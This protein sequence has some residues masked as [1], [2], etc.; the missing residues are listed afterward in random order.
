MKLIRKPIKPAW[1]PTSKFNASNFL[2]KEWMPFL[3]MVDAAYWN[4]KLQED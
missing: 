2:R 4:T 1:W 3:S